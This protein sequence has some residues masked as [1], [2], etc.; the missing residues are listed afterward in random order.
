MLSGTSQYALRSVL[1]LAGRTNDAPIPAPDIAEALE[2]PDNYLGKILYQLARTGILASSRGKRGGFSLARPATRLSLLDIVKH[3][4]RFDDRRTC[5]LG[6]R[7]CSDGQPCAAHDKWREV[8]EQLTEF[9]SKTT[10]ADLL[11]KDP[12]EGSSALARLTAS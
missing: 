11:Q 6:R 8:S 3:F 5:L 1:F 7:E 2:I 9:F 4:D 10:V 12:Q